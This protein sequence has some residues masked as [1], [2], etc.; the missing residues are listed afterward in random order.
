M[1]VCISDDTSTF[2]RFF[3]LFFKSLHPFFGVPPPHAVCRVVFFFNARMDGYIRHQLTEIENRV[4]LFMVATLSLLH[5]SESFE[6][7]LDTSYS[8]LIL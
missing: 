5:P 2:D 8:N 1:L 7:I 3:P 6:N 4:R